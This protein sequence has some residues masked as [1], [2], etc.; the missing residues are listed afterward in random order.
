MVTDAATT[1]SYSGSS[2]SA[3]TSGAT[4]AAA[5]TTAAAAEA[6]FVSLFTGPLVE[7]I[8]RG[9]GALLVTNA[10]WIACSWP[11]AVAAAHGIALSTFAL[12]AVYALN[13]WHD[14]EGDLADPKKNQR[15]VDGLIRHHTGFGAWLAFVHVAL[16]VWAA[17]ALGTAAAA[18][19][20]ALLCVNTAYSYTLKGVPL[21]DLVVV[22]VWGAAFAAIV[23]SEALWWAAVGAMTS[24]M[25]LFQ[26]KQDHRVDAV[27]GI[28]TTF[29]RLPNAATAS[30]VAICVALGAALGQ[31]TGALGALSAAIPLAL[32]LAIP[33]TLRA[34]MACRAYCGVALAAALWVRFVGVG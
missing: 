32:Y 14:A 3:A 25:H 8:R 23:S 19:V 16:V 1:A 33:D 13:D 6:S 34:W 11:G 21:V 12:M 28:T 15:L 26:I 7:R 10:A 2:D 29:V 27:N 22:G 31:L 5:A 30:L 4:A 18:G 17:L 9:E 24:I 20:L